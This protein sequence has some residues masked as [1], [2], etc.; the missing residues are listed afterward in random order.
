MLTRSR[1]LEGAIR[2]LED[3]LRTIRDE[4]A[5]ADVT[6]PVSGRVH[7][8]TVHTPGAVLRPA[9]TVLAIVPQNAPMIVEARMEPNTIDD[10]QYGSSATVRLPAF[11]TRTTPELKGTIARISPDRSTDSVTGQ[12]YYQVEVAVSEEE[13]QRA[14]D[15]PTDAR[16]ASRN[17]REDRAE[18][19][20][21]LCDETAD[22]PPAQR[23]ARGVELQQ[24]R[25]SARHRAT[26]ASA[27]RR[28]PASIRASCPAGV[29]PAARRARPIRPAGSSHLAGGELFA[30]IA[31]VPLCSPRRALYPCGPA[32]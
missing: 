19:P 30:F 25:E 28:R 8:S 17:L 27:S 21:Q 15:T 24:R 20:P 23:M 11:N 6:A 9:E 5:S 22:R 18:K 14:R 16:N 29:Q 26:R 13:M 1:S 7:G 2:D 3:N 31:W 10:I 12:S 4:L 32:G